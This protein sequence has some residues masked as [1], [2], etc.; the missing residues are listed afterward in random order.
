MSKW[1]NCNISRMIGMSFAEV[2]VSSD[3]TV[4]V[5]ATRRTRLT[6]ARWECRMIHHQECS[7]DVWLEDVTGDLDDLIGSEIVQAS[8]D[9]SVGDTDM[10]TQTATFYTFRTHKGTVQFR[11]LGESNGYY[12]EDVDIEKRLV[13]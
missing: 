5:F 6:K 2:S 7:E 1:V 13:F 12:S 10:G 8:E 11:W 3:K 4:V 9:V